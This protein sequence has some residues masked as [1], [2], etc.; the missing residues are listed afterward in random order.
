M[1]VG[2]KLQAATWEP[3]PTEPLDRAGE[4]AGGRPPWLSPPW[5]GEP[6]REKPLAGLGAAACLQG[7]VGDP[8][9]L[10]S[11]GRHVLSCPSLNH[12]TCHHRECT[13]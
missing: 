6:E 7:S 5:R 3:W 11:T 13:R 1:G 9:R 10:P 12:P 4:C 8:G 2:V